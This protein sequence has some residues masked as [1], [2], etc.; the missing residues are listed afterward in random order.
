MDIVSLISRLRDSNIDLSLVEDDLE[1]SYDG[2]GLSPAVLDEI[3]HNKQGI[4]DLLRRITPGATADIPLAT[5]QADYPMT[6][7]QRRLWVLS[8]SIEGNVAYNIP[9]IYL[10]E[11]SLDVDAL[12]HA[13]KALVSRHEIL[14]TVFKAG[15]Q[16]EVRQYIHPPGET[17]F[18][19]VY[20][21][22]REEADREAT[23][24]A[25]VKADSARQ[26]DLEAGPL[27]RAGIYRVEEEK[28]VL[29]CVV[30]HIVCDGWSVNVFMKDLLLAYNGYRRGITDPMP[31]LK[32]QYRDYSLWHLGQLAGDLAGLHGTYWSR[33]FSGELPVLD[34]PLAAP[35]P[36]VKTFRGASISF[37][38]G[39]DIVTE[40]R[41][42]CLQQ[43][44]TLFMGLVGV[45]DVLLYRYTGQGD[46]IIGTPV[47]GRDHADLE[48]QIGL[49]ANTLALRTILHEDDSFM[50]VVGRA[51]E[52][53]LGAFQ[54]QVYPFDVLVEDLGLGRDRSRNPLFDIMLV[55]QNTSAG[56]TGSRQDLD[57]VAVRLFDDEQAAVSRFDLSLFFTETFRD[58]QLT[59]EYNSDLFDKDSIQRLGRHLQQIMAVVVKSPSLPV[60][61]LDYL[62]AAEK[63]QVLEE[64]NDTRMPFPADQTLVSLFEAQARLTPDKTAIVAGSKKCSFGEL[65]ILS[66]QLGHYLRER[67]GVGRGD[68]VAVELE[69]SEWLIAGLMGVLK[70]GAAYLPIDPGYPQQRVDFI[71]TDSKAVCLLDSAALDNFIA[72][73]SV[74]SPVDRPSTSEPGDLA[75]VI[76]TSGSS[77]RP[78]GCLLEHRGVVNRIAWMWH[79]YG[80]TVMD[81]ILQ[82]TTFTFDVSV[83]E[84]FMPLCFGG[85]IVLCGK[86]DAASPE[87]ISTLISAEGVTCLHFV[88]G[89]LDAFLAFLSDRPDCRLAMQSLRLVI[90]SGEALS[91][92]T[93]KRW[94]Q[95]SGVSLH[96]LYGPTEASVDVTQ[97]ST[98]SGDTRIPIG[99]PIWNTR[100]DIIDSN[101]LPAPVGIPGELCIGGIGLARGYLNRPELTAER[102]VANPLRPGDRMYRTGDL[103]RWLANGNIEFLGR[104]DMQVKIRGYRIEP[105]EIESAFRRLPGVNAAVVIARTDKTGDSSLAAYFTGPVSLDAG[106]I[107]AWL[108]KSLPAYMLPSYYVR[109][110]RLPQNPSGKI[111]RAR[112]PDPVGSET[113][114]GA[115]Y[116]PPADET[117]AELARI[118]TG[119]LGRERVG[120]CDDFFNLGGHSLKA[121]RLATHICRVF[122]VKM[123]LAQVFEYP[124][125]QQQA[126]FIRQARREIWSPICPAGVRRHYP[127]SYPQRRI[128]MLC[129][130]EELNRAYNLHGEYHIRG[131]LDPAAL[132]YAIRALTAR[133]EVLRTV[134]REDEMGE[135]RQFILP[136]VENAAIFTCEDLRAADDSLRN[137]LSVGTLK[138]FDLANGPLLRAG[139]YRVA[140]D[141][142]VLAYVMHHIISDAWSMDI[143]IRELWQLYDARVQGH[144]EDLPS[145]RIQ[146][147]D[148]AVWQAEQLDAPSLARHQA[149]WLEQFSGELPVLELPLDAPRPAVGRHNGAIATVRIEPR[150]AEDLRSLC[151]QQGCSLSMGLLALVNAL[152]FRY[153]GQEDII[154][155]SPITMRDHLDLG[156]QPGFYTNTLALRTRFKGE[157][158]YR[159]LLDRVRAISINAFRHYAYPF[160]LLLDQLRLEKDRSR[161]ALFD[162]LVHVHE[163]GD[164]GEERLPAGLKITPYQEAIHGVSKFDLSFNFVA[165]GSGLSLYLEYDTDLFYA[166]TIERMGIHLACM[167]ESVLTSPDAGIDRLPYLGQGE[168]HALLHEFNHSPGDDSGFVPV[169]SLFE[170]R[171]RIHPEVPALTCGDRMVSYGELIEA[172]DRLAGYL[173]KVA[174]PGPGAPVGI[175]ME[176][177]VSMVIGILAVLRSGNAYLPIEPDYPGARIRYILQDAGVTVLLSQTASL[178][179]VEC[180]DGLVVNLDIIWAELDRDNG[181]QPVAL[182]PDDLAY[183]IY[184]SGSTGMPKGCAITHRGLSNYIQW[185][186]GY[187]FKDSERPGWGL[188]TPLSF[189]LTVTSIFC[190][191]TLGGTLTIYEQQLGLPEILTDLFSREVIDSIKLTPSHISLLKQLNLSS[192]KVVRAIV[193]GEQITNEQVNILKKIN[194]AMTVFNEY[195]P[196]ETTVGCTVARLGQHEPILIGKPV[197]NTLIYVLDL[198]RQL[199]GIGIAGEIGIGGAGLAQ[200]YVHNPA[201][202]AEKFVADPFRPGERIYLTGD[203]GKWL[204]DGNLVYLGRK[205]GQVKLRGY[206]I[207]IGELESLLQA[208]PQVSA[209]AVSLWIN[210]GGEKELVA[211]IAT[212]D[213]IPATD[214]H[215]YLGEYLPAYMLPARYIL[216]ASLPISSNGKVDRKRLPVPEELGLSAVSS[217]IPPRNHV[218]AHLAQLWQQL[219]AR[220]QISVNDDFI[221]LGANS[222]QVLRLVTNLYINFQVRISVKDVF[223][224]PVLQ[225]LALTVQ[226]A[227]QRNFQPIDPAPLQPDYPLSSSQRRL[228]AVN[229]LDSE[230]AAYN[231]QGVLVFEGDFDAAAL[232]YASRTLIGRHESLRTAFR[233]NKD[234]E[235][236][237]VIIPAEAVVFKPYVRDLTAEDGPAAKAADLLRE[238]SMKPFD[239]AVAPLI[240]TYLFRVACRKWIFGFLIHHII[241][242][243][244]SLQILSRELLLLYRAR[245]GREDILLPPTVLQFS[246][247]A[248]WQQQ[249]AM[250]KFDLHRKYWLDHLADELPVFD[251]PGDHPRPA[252]KT[253]K[254]AAV[255][256]TIAA[257]A[258]GAFKALIRQRGC[259]LFIGLLALVRTLLYRYTQQQDLIIGTQ[260][261]GREH[262]DLENLVGLFLNTLALR[263]RVDGSESFLTVLDKV[264]QVATDGYAHQA[265]PF[266]LLVEELK[267]QRDI[268]RSALFDVVV[269]LENEEPGRRGAVEDLPGLCITEYN[270]EIEHCKFDLAFH[271]TERG[272]AV[273]LVVVYNREI[274][275]PDAIRRIADHT[276]SLLEAILVDPQLPIG[277]LKYLSRGE[278]ERLLGFNNSPAF[279]PED[280]TVVDLFRQ[281]VLR[282]PESPAL[283]FEGVTLSYRG[284]DAGSARL[285]ARLLKN[286]AIRAGSIVAIML[287]RS[288]DM[289]LAMLA[290]LK[291]GAAY[292]PIDPELPPSRIEFLLQDSGAALLLTSTGYRHRVHFQGGIVLVPE[293]CPADSLPTVLPAGRPHPGDLAYII[294][295]SGSTGQPKGVMI[296]H[297]CLMDYVSGIL[298]ATNM[299]ECVHF[300]LMSTLAADLGNTVLYGALLTGGA[301][302]IYPESAMLEPER[303]F[304]AE[305]DCIKI[306]PS[307]WKSLQR[308]DKIFLPARCLI[309]GGEKLAPELLATIREAGGRCEIYNHYGP[310]ETTIGKLIYRVDLNGIPARV[311]LGKPFCRS[312]VYILDNY[313]QPVPEGVIGEIC[314]AGVGVA[315]GYL[316]RS[317]LT[318]RCFV[319]D[320]FANARRMYRTGDLGRRLADGSIEFF[321]RRDDQIKVRGFRIEPGEIENRL[322]CHEDIDT[323]LVVAGP[324]KD[325]DRQLI[326]YVIGRRRLNLPQ[327]RAYLTDV[328]PSH[329]VPDHLV[330]LDR[331]PL[332]PNGKVDRKKLPDPA[333]MTMAD[334]V[335]YVPP[336]S[337]VESKLVAIWEDRL[338]KEKIGI[339]DDFFSLGGN[340]LKVIGILKRMMDETGV[341]VPVKV[342]FQKRSIQVI[343]SYISEQTAAKTVQAGTPATAGLAAREPRLRME[344][345]YNQLSFLS[346]W[347]RGNPLVINPYEFDSL[348]LQAFGT[349]LNQLIER[350]EILRTRF[351]RVGDI[352][353]QEV[354]P[355]RECRFEMPEIIALH[356]QQELMV[357]IEKA[358]ASPLDPFTWPLIRLELYSPDRGGV[359]ALV[360]MHHTITD[361]YSTGILRNELMQLYEAALTGGPVQWKPLAYQY[362]DFARWQ[363]EYL[364]S[365]AGAGHKDYWLK[366]LAG[367]AGVTAMDMIPF[368]DAS[369]TTGKSICVNRVIAG[370]D[371]A[372]ID[373]FTKNGGITRPILLMGMLMLLT[374]YLGGGEDISILVAV[375]GRDNG[376]D[377]SPDLS[378]LIGY[379]VNSLIVRSRM[380][381]DSPVTE[382]L[383]MVQ[384][385]FLED[386]SHDCYPIQKLIYELPGVQP[387]GFLDEKVAFNYHNYPYLHQHDYAFSPEERHGLMELRDP[388]QTL[389]GLVVKEYRN[390]IKLE[391]I[392][393]HMRFTP[394]RALEL[395]DFYWAM[396][397]RVVDD[398]AITPARLVGDDSY[399]NQ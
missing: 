109:L 42:L 331:L 379:F 175:L 173:E 78:K 367:Y 58:I 396:L 135:P 211:Y 96:N 369:G 289:V 41:S 178:P 32:L 22:L 137:R 348:D 29:A 174:G 286:S 124:I 233:K 374:K 269:A 107:R 10:F 125:L 51:K 223:E 333:T 5:A 372:E 245:C 100:M 62:S 266:D 277:Q 235:V 318:S 24:R 354:K 232:D 169:F 288:G 383:T 36:A 75:Y 39:P 249:T 63:R 387:R 310:T 380:P 250:E 213:K 17:R 352:I 203:L 14:R 119:V 328:L 145:P 357:C 77:G 112:L 55:L 234:G 89:M 193:G 132:E 81:I 347:K 301:L 386:L 12:R 393:D 56:Y 209:A 398:P 93:V 376:Y 84:I 16:G 108:A 311:P 221:A 198:H 136:A 131:G 322:R 340:S 128:W 296:R 105:G 355:A 165:S 176:R 44:A 214:L 319:P 120:I 388:V 61:L 164:P 341:A 321:G 308:K 365:S 68:I 150:A 251:L 15:D 98:S 126:E 382:I 201:L 122:G 73:R 72:E 106:E 381:T 160:E 312:A 114:A 87:R 117:E 144:A 364:D 103:G 66:N 101:G 167:L 315:S 18:E 305:L 8:R 377:R 181:F 274:F 207:E 115:S 182:A 313:D 291:A 230:M 242:D 90:T 195:G 294:Y 83:W 297:E 336:G 71:L 346:G 6:P 133:H 273:E 183:V 226:Q 199:C 260:V 138:P 272:E 254:G 300:G 337:E 40:F 397:Q 188:F 219:L 43:G 92:G 212:E 151:R 261:A 237:Q 205:D 95:M 34:L 187:Y 9:G 159:D 45:L 307:H 238:E 157:G 143:L 259:T 324:G 325:E 50:D 216:L 110:D 264:R 140:E 184:T 339:N 353:M 185:A 48:D 69:R 298:A 295:T 399:A 127:L 35:R 283:V 180:Y 141:G 156:D 279:L 248:Y 161:N 280:Q 134:F 28:W 285:A 344:A 287:D 27:L 148:Y 76:Y 356:S 378:G 375:S 385:G 255:N 168:S 268:S 79:H 271:F 91:L 265:Y 326:A 349:A 370:Q 113:G 359:F 163:A 320:P 366:K 317:E 389:L 104:I 11:G 53:T 360:S 342:F 270:S 70:S 332:T 186:N 88:P 281:Q 345:S 155:G 335:G 47:A 149:F 46:I 224:K 247:Y 7:A 303:I 59:L 196:T 20:R 194:P 246:D 200:C 334:A 229:Q 231:M 170:A 147:K 314:I 129:Q 142:W 3:K 60:R 362:R 52:I 306:V 118:W 304:S 257:A 361:G 215:A 253:N 206:R 208:H 394:D 1:V 228:W 74:W 189:D 116:L 302:H 191:L 371:L 343:A 154:I 67:H 130:F 31:P 293:D 218:E 316:G 258:T 276:A 19:P 172:A 282:M 26:F 392:F 94:Y 363:R 97:F 227:R 358:H 192:S 290:V 292:L 25:M 350:H 284:L 21:D 202:T 64:F 86:G 111:D 217:Y 243:G 146:Y 190:S 80:F 240:R 373:A 139:L 49:Y 204:P 210:A 239:L 171:S 323:A 220:E 244:W 390:C 65:N 162:V 368:P 241:C 299:R 2:E 395:Q 197:A 54:H 225:A 256:T 158:S 33:Q 179:G 153:T 275:L 99:R 166:A 267:V 278:L 152:L 4:V 85:K 330:E 222:L 263:T 102:F 262:P 177:S 123:D 236:R 37:P 384:Q 30:H 13:L 82:K 309:F 327:L 391:F 121:N 252:I 329:L 338:G 38:V 23:L 351:V 57:G